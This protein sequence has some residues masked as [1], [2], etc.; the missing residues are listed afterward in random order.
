LTEIG[1][2]TAAAENWKTQ[3]KRASVRARVH[4]DG[5]LHHNSQFTSQEEEEEECGEEVGLNYS[6]KWR[7]RVIKKAGGGG[8]EYDKKQPAIS[9]SRCVYQKIDDDYW[10]SW[11]KMKKRKREGKRGS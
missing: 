10:R 8:V 3:T 4:E 1:K 2:T 6:H 11:L 7:L 9:W 5:E